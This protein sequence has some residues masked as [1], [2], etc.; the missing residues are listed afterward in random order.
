MQYFI[1]FFPLMLAVIPEPKMF[2][3]NFM[4]FSYSRTLSDSF[5]FMQE[6]GSELHMVI[7]FSPQ[8]WFLFFSTLILCLNHHRL[9]SF[10]QQLFFWLLLIVYVLDIHR[11]VGKT[12]HNYSV[13]VGSS[14]SPSQLILRDLKST[15]M[16]GNVSISHILCC[17]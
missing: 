6:D 17:N 2:F 12:F 5:V 11:S 10:P 14:N 1:M 16:K 8:A 4:P 7:P 3:Q 13:L 15:C 9:G